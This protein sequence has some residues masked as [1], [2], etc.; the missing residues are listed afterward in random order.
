MNL[1]NLQFLFK[2]SYWLMLYP[3]NKDVDM[4]IN[5]LLDKYE[6]SELSDSQCRCKLGKADI[7]VENRPYAAIRLH[8][9]PLEHYR[10]SLSLNVC[11]G[12]KKAYF[13]LW[14]ALYAS[15]ILGSISLHPI[16]SIPFSSYPI[17]EARPYAKQEKTSPVS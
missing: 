10:P 11:I 5:E 1:R 7:W 15:I 6:F 12:S 17:I 16:T 14:F 3:Y 9:T 4:I 8:E 2:P 13:G